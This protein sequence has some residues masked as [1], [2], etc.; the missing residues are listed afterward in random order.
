MYRM[1]EKLHTEFKTSRT[2]LRLPDHI[3]NTHLLYTLVVP[4]RRP[5]RKVTNI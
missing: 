1:Q 3:Y 5:L 4:L 2:L